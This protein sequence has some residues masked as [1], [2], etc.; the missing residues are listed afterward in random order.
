[1]NKIE[2]WVNSPVK[3][4]DRFRLNGSDEK[5]L[6]LG[7]DGSEMICNTDR[8]SDARVRIRISDKRVYKVPED[9]VGPNPFLPQTIR[10]TAFGIESILSYIGFGRRSQ[11]FKVEQ[12]ENITY[13]YSNFNPFFIIDGK[14]EFYQRGN[15]WTI[16]QKMALIT[17]IY[18]GLEAGRIIVHARS[19]ETQ[20][21][22]ALSGF[23]DIAARDIVDGKQR[24]TTIIEFVEDK[25]TDEF[26][27]TYSELAPSAQRKFMQ[28]QGIL[29]GEMSENCT[30]EQICD[31]FLNNTVTGTPISQSHLEY[32]ISLKNQLSK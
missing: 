25:F 7:Q 27:N 6:A 2:N 28:Y 8:R 17:T 10:F 13:N 20:K 18:R 23:P 12:D 14:R 26:G 15:V 24:L 21:K 4:S 11:V 19:Y 5:Y 9:Y 31:A 1:V 3:E 30:P 32:I 29:Y 16:D 22:L